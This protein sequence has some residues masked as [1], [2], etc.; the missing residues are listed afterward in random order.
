M[1]KSLVCCQGGSRVKIAAGGFSELE[2]FDAVIWMG[3]MNYRLTSIKGQGEQVAT[4]MNMEHWEVLQT[5][6]QLNLEKKM[7]RTGTAYS[8]GNIHFAPTYKIN[9]GTDTYGSKKRAPAWTDRILFRCNAGLLTLMNY[10]SNNLVKGSDH[11]PVYAQMML[12]FNQ[13]DQTNYLLVERKRRESKDVVIK[14]RKL[15]I[16]RPNKIVPVS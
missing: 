6:C 15:K 12:K 13:H 14:K 9:I 1:L 3:D 5:M 4:L 11:R 8:E 7:Q 10:D 2:H 16:P